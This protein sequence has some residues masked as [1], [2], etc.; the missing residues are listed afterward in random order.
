MNP[1]LV[2]PKGRAATLATQGLPSFSLGLQE[3]KGG[4]KVVA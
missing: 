2:E 3:P 4:E 1:K